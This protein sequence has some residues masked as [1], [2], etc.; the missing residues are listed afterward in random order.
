MLDTA[1]IESYLWGMAGY[2]ALVLLLML[3]ACDRAP[4]RSLEGA[5]PAGPE[6]TASH[7]AHAQTRSPGP[8]GGRIA[9]LD[10][11]SAAVLKQALESKDYAT[12]LIAIE[13]VA[14][15]HAEPLL[16]WLEHAL[17]DPEHDVRMAA[18]EALDRMHSTRALTLL[19]TVRDDTGEELDV[20]AVAAGALIRTTP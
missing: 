2:T 7:A 5:P 18:V 8:P 17:G 13:A 6:P 3:A 1:K 14:D 20:C 19:A 11:A 9:A 10:A 15:A 16:G 4:R 12:R